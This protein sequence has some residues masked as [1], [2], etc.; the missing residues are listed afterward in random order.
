VTVDQGKACEGDDVTWFQREPCDTLPVD[1][2]TP[3]RVQ[4]KKVVDPADPAKL[5]MSA[6]Y[7]WVVDDQMVVALPP[8][9]DDGLVKQVCFQAIDNQE[10]VPLWVTGRIFNAAIGL[11]GG[12]RTDGFLG[13]TRLDPDVL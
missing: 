1:K 5:G 11:Y 9:I 4:V 7:T 2:R 13:G 12:G 10:G 8:N 3:G 6:R